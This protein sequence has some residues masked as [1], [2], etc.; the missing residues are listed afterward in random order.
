MS[1]HSLHAYPITVRGCAPCEAAYRAEAILIYAIGLAEKEGEDFD[2]L[3][4]SAKDHF[5]RK[6]TTAYDEHEILNSKGECITCRLQEVAVEDG[7]AL[8]RAL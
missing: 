7:A 6:A 8:T 2:D 3:S 4:R 5:T 1:D